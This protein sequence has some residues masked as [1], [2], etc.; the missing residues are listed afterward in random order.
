[1]PHPTSMSGPAS[2]RLP[3]AAL[4]LAFAGPAWAHE[5]VDEADGVRVSTQVQVWG[6]LFD[7]DA[8][9]QAD[10]AGYGDPEHD[11]GLL[12]QRAFV[13]LEGRRGPVDFEFEIGTGA[14]YDAIV[15]NPSRSIQPLDAYVGY[16]AKLSAGE[17][18]LSAGNQRAAFSRET[19]TSSAEL[20]FEER[21]VNVQWLAP[22]RDMGL[23]AD[24]ALNSGLRARLSV[25]NGRGALPGNPTS[26]LFGD[27]NTGKMLVGRIEYAKGET[28]RPVADGDAFGIAAAGFWDEG[29]SART[30]TLGFDAFARFGRLSATVEGEYARVSPVNVDVAPPDLLAPTTR[31]GAMGQIAYLIPADQGGWLVAGR[32][33]WFD[34]DMSTTENNG[35]VGNAQLGLTRKD[36][37]PGL[38]VGGAFVHRLEGG[39]AGVPNDTLRMWV[40]YR[41]KV[42][43]DAPRARA[44]VATADTTPTSNATIA[45][46]KPFLGSWRGQGDLDGARI[47]LWEQPGLGLV[48]SFRMDRPKG[49]VEVGRPY[50]LEGFAYDTETGIL[51]VRLDPHGDGKEVVWF[52]LASEASPKG[53]QLCGWGYEDG[54]RE[55]AVNGVGGGARV[56]WARADNPS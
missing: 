4:A 19:L 28:Y 23:F 43:V 32:F 24:L 42:G 35:D 51:R 36:L 8:D 40:Q 12:L 54:R 7:Q 25:Q 56:C 39:G 52:E 1:M 53:P 22:A 11:P 10:G 15:P 30:G 45:W 16:T 44:A 48:G 2:W 49:Q 9:R 29:L 34:D 55:D 18:R 41:I 31:W 13:G 26:G 3:G 17:L 47:D 46:P 50:P 27:D 37:A 5:D 6:V 33:A 14:P 38:D 20:P 21:S